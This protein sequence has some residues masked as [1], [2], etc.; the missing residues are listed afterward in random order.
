MTLTR[1]EVAERKINSI[2]SVDGEGNPD[3]E[4]KW[5]KNLFHK[6]CIS[7]TPHDFQTY[8]PG[9][10]LIGPPPGTKASG[11]EDKILIE[12]L[13]LNGTTEYNYNMKEIQKA[14]NFQPYDRNISSEKGPI[15][16]TYFDG[17][18]IDF[19]KNFDGIESNNLKDNENIVFN[20]L[21]NQL[22]DITAGNGQNSI[23]ILYDASTGFS[24]RSWL[25]TPVTN[26]PKI[27]QDGET[28]NQ[29]HT[30]LLDDTVWLDP[31]GKINQQIKNEYRSTKYG[32]SVSL[33]SSN[34]ECLIIGTNIEVPI[35]N[36]CNGSEVV[37]VSV[38]ENADE[39]QLTI[40]YPNLGTDNDDNTLAKVGGYNPL[41]I[42]GLNCHEPFK[43][44]ISG[45]PPVND[46]TKFNTINNVIEYEKK[47]II[48]MDKRNFIKRS[49]DQS[50]AGQVILYND[51]EKGIKNNKTT[52]LFSNDR[53]LISYSI[54][55]DC[56]FLFSTQKQIKYSEDD[57]TLQE[58]S[59]KNGKIFRYNPNVQIDI[60]KILYQKF[61][62]LKNY[63]TFF[64][65]YQ[66]N[67]ISDTLENAFGPQYP[68]I[69]DKDVFEIFEQE[70]SLNQIFNAVR[71]IWD[72]FKLLVAEGKDLIK[73]LVKN[74]DGFLVSA[75]QYQIKIEERV[76]EYKKLSIILSQVKDNPIIKVTAPAGVVEGNLVTVPLYSEP[77]DTPES[78]TVRLPS[79]VSGGSEFSINV[80]DAVNQ[81]ILELANEAGEEEFFSDL[82][83]FKERCSLNIILKNFT[84][85]NPI[86]IPGKENTIISKLKKFY[87][88][89]TPILKPLFQATKI[90][91]EKSKRK[92]AKIS[93]EVQY[94]VP[95][96]ILTVILNFIN[97]EG[98]FSDNES[99]R[100]NEKL[101]NKKCRILINSINKNLDLIKQFS[102]KSDLG[103][104]A[105]FY[106][107][108]LFDDYDEPRGR[109]EKVKNPLSYDVREEKRKHTRKTGQDMRQNRDILSRRGILTLDKDD[110]IVVEPIIKYM[111]RIGNL[112]LNYGVDDDY[113]I[114][115]EDWNNDVQSDV[116]MEQREWLNN[117]KI[118]K[119]N[120]L[121]HIIITPWIKEENIYGLYING[122]V[123]NLTDQEILYNNK[124]VYAGGVGS[125]QPF[126]NNIFDGLD[127][128]N[129]EKW[130]NNNEF[131]Y[132]LLVLLNILNNEPDAPLALIQQL[133]GNGKL[134]IINIID[135]WISLL[136]PETNKAIYLQHV[137]I[138][139]KIETILRS[140]QHFLQAQQAQPAI[141]VQSKS[142]Y[143]SHTDLDGEPVYLLDKPID[144]E[145]EFGGGKR[146]KS[147]KKNKKSK[148]K[149]T[150]KRKN[151][152]TK[153]RRNKKYTKKRRNKK[154][155]KRKSKTIKKFNKN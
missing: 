106:G 10:C 120:L 101:Y 155:R 133:I 69:I 121:N 43:G 84:N 60:E 92:T 85:K 25:S 80:V 86:I 144:A 136:N 29:M 153:K 57:G 116:T 64:E 34:I 139:K 119:Q 78:I 35:Y 128:V 5:K 15:G 36:V 138:N 135:T 123:I 149:Y 30:L 26:A 129:Q 53:M 3:G 42:T 72:Q 108:G 41:P 7:D 39:E 102:V 81:K 6:I 118:K 55:L 67:F 9:A 1:N 127:L 28:R 38:G 100:D 13:T 73:G 71:E 141:R 50:E 99:L 87:N 58:L 4:E 130:L 32:E 115:E 16:V 79:G 91:R 48:T 95:Y 49:G 62:L 96:I 8:P 82:F 142:E 117:Q 90:L 31:A 88:A 33:V 134:D 113:F 154:N 75:K 68:D 51:K 103:R 111:E 98:Q 112:F 114:Y 137:P 24:I 66:M 89:I 27:D 110:M 40:I 52:Y 97:T 17:E 76:Q 18:Y 37:F 20:E 59:S 132:Y 93:S 105:K 83:K 61:I 77:S 151:K 145:M 94:K 46:D 11:I 126:F 125:Y 124:V 147:I 148:K 14:L 56:P 45:I 19:F 107:G 65:E 146:I 143:N 23:N 47:G 109:K 140:E 70:D 74:I 131:K 150:K 104:L 22:T 152:Y 12:V 44:S 122:V 21:N 54:L 2:I 63:I